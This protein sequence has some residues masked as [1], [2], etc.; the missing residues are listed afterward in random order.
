MNKMRALPRLLLVLALLLPLLAACGAEPT[1]ASVPPTHTPRPAVT[2]RPTDT[3]GPSDTPELADTPTPEPT[4]T[5]EPTPAPAALFEAAACPFDLPAG[6]V[7]GE[8][9]E[10]GYLTVPEDR[11]DPD[12]P[13]IRLAV[14]LF[15]H[16]DGDPEPDPVVYLEGGPG[17]SALEFIGLTFAELAKPVFAANRDLVV[18]DQRGVGLSEPA[19]DC[20]ELLELDRELLDWEVDGETVTEQEAND[21]VL[22]TTIA[23]GEALAQV[24]DLSAYNTAANADDVNDLRLAL[25]YD[26]V[27]LWGVSYGTHLALAVM[28][29]HPEGLRSVVLDSVYPL[30]VDLY[31]EALPNAARAFDALFDG[32]AA[33][34]GCNTHYP[35]LRTVFFETVDRLN[36]TPASF[37]VTDPFSGES[38][39]MVMTGD[40][41]VSA[42]FQFLHDT[43][44]VPSLPEII[45]DAS[46]NTF[47]QAARV[48]GVLLGTGEAVS[49]GTHF[50]VQCHDELT[51][52]TLEQYEAVAAEYPELAA[53]LDYSILGSMGYAVCEEWGAGQ[54][55]A[56]EN[57]AVTSDIPALI[58]A[59][60]Y[61]PI[62]AP[63]WGRHAAETL[64]NG[65][66]YEYPGV[67]HGASVGV[68][69]PRDM[70][71][72][73]LDDPTR[74][75][76]DACIAAMDLPQFV[77][78]VEAGAIELEPFTNEQMGIQGLIPAGWTEVNLGVYARNR[79]ATDAAVLLA[80]AAPVTADDLLAL[81]SG[82]LG[83]EEPPEAVGEREANGLRWT[84]YA[85]MVQGIEIDMALTEADG[86]ALIVLLQSDPGE[87]EALYQ[88]VFLPVID[89]L[90]PTE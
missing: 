19:L 55:G 57:R 80:Q 44:V 65:Y 29:D 67:G 35:D 28:R 84:L 56:I 64:E 79:S 27:N 68:D 59:G 63:S 6:Q 52:S 48:L 53:F 23:C 86:L 66:F 61:D 87:H 47:G 54:A 20:P 72:A 88:A 77:V 85:V 30:D 14:A 38:Y 45:Y 49:R 75:P 70:M 33:D 81:V 24:A 78:P 69:C 39:E 36:E 18:L 51:F 60:E 4:D 25:G 50:S 76:D 73:F 9:V 90:V 82:Q 10:C 40:D 83:L 22:Q 37:Q 1:P 2:A 17:G 46:Q 7:E 8:T 5:P 16:P 43:N 31:L 42:V 41:L 13:T 15:H 34:E 26:E 3:P 89:A 12:S 32:C 74:A 62:T 21:L 58:L 11:A 71:V